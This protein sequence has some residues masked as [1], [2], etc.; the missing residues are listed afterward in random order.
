MQ[1]WISFVGGEH[2]E[3][4]NP[5][6]GAKEEEEGKL[7][8]LHSNKWPRWLKV[9]LLPSLLSSLCPFMI[10][11]FFIPEY[12]SPSF[13]LLFSPYDEPPAVE[14]EAYRLFNFREIPPFYFYSWDF[15]HF[16]D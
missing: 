15:I 7:Q 1:N 14:I 10:T 3:S 6:F 13:S 4:R 2:E 8:R 12:L 9:R 5:A 11:S 16:A